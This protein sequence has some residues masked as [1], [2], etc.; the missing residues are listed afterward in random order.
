M[1]SWVWVPY[2]CYY[3]WYSKGDAIRCADA[4]NTSWVVTI[5][6]SQ[7]REF[8]AAMI[9]LNEDRT[10][11]IKWDTTHVDFAANAN[12]TARFRVGF[13]FY[14]TTFLRP[15]VSPFTRN[16]SS[17][18]MFYQYFNMKPSMVRVC[19]I[20]CLCT[21]RCGSGQHFLAV[22]AHW[23]T[24]GQP[25]DLLP[26]QLDG[27]S[28]PAVREPNHKRP[29]VVVM[30]HAGVWSSARMVHPPFKLA[31]AGC[32]FGHHPPYFLLCAD[33]RERSSLA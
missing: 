30:N 25:F 10:T 27:A 24:S 2:T 6:D 29:D 16:F 20:P 3:H 28:A 1:C 15:N 31:L 26:G 8:M 23:Q 19:P 21:C 33:I 32:L 9:E 22:A 7:P 5:G 18:E 13:Q 14:A 4:T 17:D 12:S 11:S